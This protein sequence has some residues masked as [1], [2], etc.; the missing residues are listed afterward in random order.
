[1]ILNSL[2]QLKEIM[3]KEYR[4]IHEDQKLAL[5]VFGDLKKLENY[6]LY[7]IST[8]LVSLANNNINLIAVEEVIKLYEDFWSNNFILPTVETLNDS[9]KNLIN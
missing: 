3:H 9:T 4:V 1:M 7:G 6:G 2:I 8:I 5:L